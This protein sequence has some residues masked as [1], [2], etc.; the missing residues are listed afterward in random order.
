MPIYTNDLAA[1]YL[2]GRKTS[3][4]IPMK[5]EQATGE[6]RS[7][8][9]SSLSKMREVHQTQNGVLAIAGQGARSRLD[10]DRMDELTAGLT[11]VAEFP[12]GLFF[13]YEPQE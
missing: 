3:A 6:Q 5:Y 4:F 12:E 13:R 2:V 11:L 9:A 10:P 8:Y 1:V 7:D